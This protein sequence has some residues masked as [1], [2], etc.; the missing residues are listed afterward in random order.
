MKKITMTLKNHLGEI[1]SSILEVSD[2]E[3]KNILSLS[4]TFYMNDQSFEI[5]TDDGFV[6]VPPEI[7][8]YSILSI[9]I[10]K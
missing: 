4:K 7:T 5:M 10:I 9:N 1:Q 3:L 8:K 2:E 6:V